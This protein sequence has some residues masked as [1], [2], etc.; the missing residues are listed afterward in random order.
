MRG[1]PGDW[2]GGGLLS[3]R[4]VS[5][6][7]VSRLFKDVAAEWTWTSTTPS[8]PWRHPDASVQQS[9]KFGRTHA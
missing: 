6:T 3:A 2:G 7:A 5:I 1:S 9:L 4:V 8:C